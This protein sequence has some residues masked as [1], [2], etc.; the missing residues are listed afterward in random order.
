MIRSGKLASDEDPKVKAAVAY[1]G[2]G[3]EVLAS[4]V[5]PLVRKAVAL[6]G[7]ETERLMQD[8]SRS[9]VGAGQ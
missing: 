9:V 8:P 4:D 3:L 7:Y 5:G 1:V 6:T 2:Y